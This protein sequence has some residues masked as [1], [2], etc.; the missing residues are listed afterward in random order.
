MPLPVLRDQSQLQTSASTPGEPPAGSGYWFHIWTS[1]SFSSLTVLSISSG[2]HLHKGLL[3]LGFLHHGIH[4][5]LGH[6]GKQEE[7]ESILWCAWYV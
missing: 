6:Q 5:H 2:V 3:Y 1:N 4:P 7:G